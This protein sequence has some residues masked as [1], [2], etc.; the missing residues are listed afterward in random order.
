MQDARDLIPWEVTDISIRP[1]EGYWSFN[2]SIH[3]D[4]TVWR[5]V[6][7]CCD[8]AM[9]DGVTVRS[10]RAV[11]GQQ[12]KNAMVIFDPKD[13]SPIQI[14]K[15]H[16]KDDL[17]RIPTPHAGY[18]DMRLFR[19]DAGGL[20]GIAA[21]LHLKRGASAS[22]GASHNSFHS[23][24]GFQNQPPEQVLLSFDEEYNIVV[25]QPIRGG[26][27]SGT[28]QKNWVPFDDVAEA[29]FLYSIGKGSMFDAGGSVYGDRAVVKP[30]FRSA[31]AT[32]PVHCAGALLPTLLTTPLPV[33][34]PPAPVPLP[35]LQGEELAQ[36]DHRARSRRPDLRN[37]I[38]GGDMRIVRGKRTAASMSGSTPARALRPAAVTRAGDE[39]MRV[40]GTGRMLLPRYEGLRG[41]TQ[42]VRVDQ[43]AWLG[44][45]HEMKFD[46]G[47]KYYWHVFY[48]VDSQGSMRAVSEPMKLASNG[49]EFAA[50]M[51]VDGD[52][53]VVSFGVDDMASRL[54]ETRLSAVMGVLQKI[55]R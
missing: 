1:Y 52:R 15:M 54:G 28:P 55:D 46:R 20:Q 29:R 53:V 32:L 4:G 9:P 5:C 47:K 43:D 14:Y 8:Y 51:A 25:A 35:I 34:L 22:D 39:S 48:L 37:M 40:L 3:F 44:I 42:L 12:T 49:I 21:S 26:G 27:W 38:R 11:T 30:S 18:E 33:P 50:G 13:W 10:N 23:P 7:R 31:T 36:E 45:G 24:L 41:G 17:S 16:E 19:T 6:L 2:P